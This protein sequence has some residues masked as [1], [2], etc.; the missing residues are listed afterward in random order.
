MIGSVQSHSS[1]KT[2]GKTDALMSAKTMKTTP[3]P[4]QEPKVADEL[5][6]EYSFDY[7]KAR[8]NRFAGQVDG[9][10]VIVMLDPDV[11]EI[12]T[13]PES[14]NKVLRALISTMPAARTKPVRRSASQS[15]P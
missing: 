9:S 7:R 11:S 5:R 1:L 15:A 8:P 10:Q 3:V 14:V 13:T 4:E 6:P 2:A 12:F